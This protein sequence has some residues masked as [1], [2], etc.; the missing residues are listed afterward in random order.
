VEL[1]QRVVDDVLAGQALERRRL[2]DAVAQ[3]DRTELGGCEGI[4]R[5]T[6][7]AI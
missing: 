1:D 5:P 2:D 6:L 7:G 4:D 3:R